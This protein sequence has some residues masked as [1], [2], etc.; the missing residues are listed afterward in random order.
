MGWRIRLETDCKYDISTDLSAAAVSTSNIAPLGD[1]TLDD[2]MYQIG[3]A[4][5]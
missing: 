5:V 4:H 2:A 1:E 3:R